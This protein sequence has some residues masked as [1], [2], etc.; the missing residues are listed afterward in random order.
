MDTQIQRI[1]AYCVKE[2]IRLTSL[3]RKI[4][5]FLVAQTM[6]LKAYQLLAKLNRE[7]HNKTYF[8]MSIYRV[9]GFLCEN[10]IVH[11]ININN[12]YILCCNPQQNMCQIFI[13]KKCN[14]VIDTGN[15]LVNDALTTVVKQSEFTITQDAIE[16]Y[17][18]CQRCLCVAV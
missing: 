11:R 5:H 7:Q 6:P 16:L 3:R 10:N 13:C 18:L 15:Q 12:S 1:E 9:L 8:I 14:K 2:N 17:G 4:I